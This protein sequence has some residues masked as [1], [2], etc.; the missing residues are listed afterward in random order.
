VALSCVYMGARCKSDCQSFSNS[1]VRSHLRVRLSSWSPELEVLPCAFTGEQRGTAM[2]MK[3]SV[4]PSLSTLERKECGTFRFDVDTATHYPL[5][6]EFQCSLEHEQARWP[7]N[8]GTPADNL[9]CLLVQNHANAT[10]SVEKP[11]TL[12][13]CEDIEND[14]DLSQ[15]QCTTITHRKGTSSKGNPDC[16]LP[17]LPEHLEPVLLIQSIECT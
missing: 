11:N 12:H 13:S 2:R 16:A 5:R 9:D 14:L 10:F 6:V 4:C 17:V 3:V 8:N 1:V 7:N 15:R